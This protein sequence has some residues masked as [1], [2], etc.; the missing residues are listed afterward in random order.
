MS[1]AIPFLPFWIFMFFFIKWP[2]P[3]W[4]N[5]PRHALSG[6]GLHSFPLSS[7]NFV[8]LILCQT[9]PLVVREETVIGQAEL[10]CRHDQLPAVGVL[11]P[12][13]CAL[14]AIRGNLQAPIITFRFFLWLRVECEFLF[15]LQ[16]FPSMWVT[17]MFGEG[18]F[19]CHF[20]LFGCHCLLNI[21]PG[22]GM[23][24]I[25]SKPG[26]CFFL[27]VLWWVLIC[28]VWRCYLPF[29]GCKTG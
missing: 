8:F 7:K 23:L 10:R 4:S 3:F 29:E 11:Y 26:M 13:L 1:R 9:L 15:K 17:F 14:C 6:V 20:M 25:V 24:T 22:L 19:C 21:V 2:S 18:F 12:W 27:L 28:I 5:L 16:G